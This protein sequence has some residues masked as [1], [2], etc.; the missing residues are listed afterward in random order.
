MIGFGSILTALRYGVEL[1]VVG[2]DLVQAARG[3]K[4]PEPE[5]RTNRD[6][7]QGQASGAAN[8]S[9]GKRAGHK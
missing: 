8:Y 7:L 3:S 4:G 9:E 1:L 5:E 2:R 6:K